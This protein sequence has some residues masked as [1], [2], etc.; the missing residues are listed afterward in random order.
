MQ[1]DVFLVDRTVPGFTKVLSTISDVF[2]AK[3]FYTLIDMPLTRSFEKSRGQFDAE[4]LLKDLVNYAPFPAD[5]A[6]YITREDMFVDD[7]NFVFGLAVGDACIVSTARLDPRFYG[8]KDLQKAKSL[9]DQ[10]LNK[11][12]IHELGHTLGIHH[13]KDRKCV[14]VYSHKIQDVDRKKKD[15]CK[16]CNSLKTQV[17]K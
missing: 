2:K 6:I 12:V 14:M 7:L 16:K 8:E 10:R 3:V 9:F 17:L 11:E 1:V 13:C 15:F 5:K 4:K